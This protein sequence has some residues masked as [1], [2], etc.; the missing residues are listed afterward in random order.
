M[1]NKN[2]EERQK[3]AKGE[4]A[5]HPKKNQKKKKEPQSQKKYWMSSHRQ[6]S[7]PSAG[8]EIRETPESIKPPTTPLQSAD[9]LPEMTVEKQKRGNEQEDENKPLDQ[10]KKQFFPSYIIID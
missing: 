3:T 5:Y 8:L 6:K 4:S 1:N 7:A 2:Q 9:I 10:N